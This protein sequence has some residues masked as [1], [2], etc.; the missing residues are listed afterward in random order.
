MDWQKTHLETLEGS[1]AMRTEDR[2]TRVWLLNQCSR[3]NRV[4]NVSKGLLQVYREELCL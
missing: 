1:E 4:S 3:P 2:S